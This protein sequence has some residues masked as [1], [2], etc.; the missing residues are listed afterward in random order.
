MMFSSFKDSTYC[1][2][3]SSYA[4]SPHLLL[5]SFT[6][7]FSFRVAFLCTNVSSVITNISPTLS[8]SPITVFLSKS[9]LLNI[10][11]HHPACLLPLKPLWHITTF[12]QCTKTCLQGHQCLLF[13]ATFSIHVSIL[14][15]HEL[16]VA[17]T[18]FSPSVSEHSSSFLPFLNFTFPSNA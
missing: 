8:Y 16:F 3:S 11:L 13:F 17:L 9:K 7:S 2:F 4:V 14:A 18:W 15:L 10:A 6:N 1:L 12:F 5:F